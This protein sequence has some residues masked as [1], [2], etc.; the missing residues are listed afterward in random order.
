MLS[1]LSRSCSSV[2]AS[3]RKKTCVASIAW[4]ESTILLL[5][6]LCVTVDLS[7]PRQRSCSCGTWRY[8]PQYQCYAQPKREGRR[9]DLPYWSSGTRQYC[10][11]PRYC[12]AGSIHLDTWSPRR[13]ENHSV[14]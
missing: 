11:D 7:R 8:S 1:L 5:S 4:C 14:A 6:L 3:C 9:L 10:P 12:R 2:F 13:G